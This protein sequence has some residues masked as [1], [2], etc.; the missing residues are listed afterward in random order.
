[1]IFGDLIPHYLILVHINSFAYSFLAETWSTQLKNGSHMARLVEP[2][3]A[4]ELR[5]ASHC[6]VQCRL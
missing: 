3:S 5:W 2:S 4:V 1:M 6:E